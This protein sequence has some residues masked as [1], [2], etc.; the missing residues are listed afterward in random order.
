[1]TPEQVGYGEARRFIDVTPEE[2]AA[3]RLE[4]LRALGYIQ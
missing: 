2:Y 3:M 1:M 4:R